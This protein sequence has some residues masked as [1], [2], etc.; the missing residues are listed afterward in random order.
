V[1]RC[2]EESENNQG[3]DDPFLFHEYTV[4]YGG[5]CGR[6][7]GKRFPEGGLVAGTHDFSEQCHSFDYRVCPLEIRVEVKSY[8]R[9]REF[10]K[11]RLAEHFILETQ[12]KFALRYQYIHQTQNVW[13]WAK[14]RVEIS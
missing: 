5:E 4:T 13:Y 9:I 3:P 7:A 2:A 6:F 12:S 11:K 14:Y 1:D 8:E 10:L